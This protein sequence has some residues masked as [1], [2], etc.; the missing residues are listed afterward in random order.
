MYSQAMTPNQ[1]IAADKPTMKRWFIWS[2]KT[3]V[4]QK[5]F[6]LVCFHLSIVESLT[7]DLQVKIFFLLYSCELFSNN[8]NFEALQEKKE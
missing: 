2:K 8:T 5:V 1:L 6:F 4:D 7:D 3:S